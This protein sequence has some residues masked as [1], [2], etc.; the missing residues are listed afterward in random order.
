MTFTSLTCKDI[1]F[2]E[3]SD[4]A[5][6]SSGSVLHAEVQVEP[7]GELDLETHPD[8]VVPFL[9]GDVQDEA[10]GET[11]EKTRAKRDQ[12]KKLVMYKHSER[13]MS[14]QVAQSRDIEKD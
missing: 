1:C 2:G 13:L 7:V 3:V 8:S 11:R 10:A 6:R 9:A 5:V 4:P 14:Y 12:N